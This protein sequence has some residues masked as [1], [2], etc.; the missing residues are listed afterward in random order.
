MQIQSEAK[1]F[2]VFG[3]IDQK[4]NIVK[5]RSESNMIKDRPGG[6]DFTSGFSRENSTQWVNKLLFGN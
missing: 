6:V 1:Y 2:C 4:T 3:I 5:N